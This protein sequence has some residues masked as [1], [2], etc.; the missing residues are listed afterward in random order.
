MK[1]QTR[2]RL[3]AVEVQVQG[4]PDFQQAKFEREVERLRSLPFAVHMT[5]AAL[6]RLA[7]APPK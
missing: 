6:R 3:V 1:R 4:Y 2:R 7:G 5:D